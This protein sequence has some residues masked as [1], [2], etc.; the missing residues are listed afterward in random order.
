MDKHPS[1]ADHRPHKAQSDDQISKRS[2]LAQAAGNKQVS[3]HNADARSL[4]NIHLNFEPRSSLN[5]QPQKYAELYAESYDSESDHDDAA[6]EESAE[7]PSGSLSPLEATVLGF[8]HSAPRMPALR[9][10]A[11][12]L[13]EMVRPCKFN[14]TLSKPEIQDDPVVSQS[15]LTKSPETSSDKC[16]NFN[17]N[18]EKHQRPRHLARSTIRRSRRNHAANNGDNTSLLSQT[19]CG[20]QASVNIANIAYT[21]EDECNG[22]LAPGAFDDEKQRARADGS[23]WNRLLYVVRSD[24]RE[25]EAKMFRPIVV[26][27]GH[28]VNR[29]AEADPALWSDNNDDSRILSRFPFCCCAARYCVAFSFVFI[30]VSAIVGFFAWPRVPTLSISSLTP[31]APAQVIYNS[32]QSQY[33]LQMPLRITYEIHSGNFY[34]LHINKAR[35]RGFDG[36]T[37]NRIIDTTLTRVPVAPLRMQFHSEA[38]RISYLTS[39]VADPAL[40]D[41]FGKCAP[42]SAPI[43][44]A[45][46]GRPGA[47]TIRFQIIVDVGGLG[48]L[49][50]PI[51]TLNHKVECPE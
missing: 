6:K 40:T 34:P 39:D 30:I 48:W 31:L 41:L 43:A 14:D 5:K 26:R 11:A 17:F 7:S 28:S 51:V 27:P 25:R 35:V 3:V 20:S 45:T 38:T 9:I 22:L 21:G 1:S 36:V 10:G 23:W 16:D 44:R 37:G 33:G 32:R 2:S 24:R 15:Q 18:S 46:D 4:P 19:E 29:D 8:E 47:L 50:Q 12:R 42:R 49:K 13:S